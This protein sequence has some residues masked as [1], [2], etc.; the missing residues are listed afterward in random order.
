M[1]LLTGLGLSIVFFLA[2]MKAL[3]YYGYNIIEYSTYIAF[4]SFIIFV[5]FTLE[6]EQIIFE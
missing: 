3:D 4:Y 2:S 6:Y 1:G 5:I